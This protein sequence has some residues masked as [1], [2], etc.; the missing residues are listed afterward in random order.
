MP[1]YL[2]ADGLQ[3]SIL[4]ALQS[5]LMSQY[6]NILRL[7]L[8]L[9]ERVYARPKHLCSGTWAHLTHLLCHLTCSY[10]QSAKGHKRAVGKLT[11]VASKQ[12]VE[13]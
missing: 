12:I 8:E 7:A 11:V 10:F 6:S 4:N 1:R 3:K 9:L 13:Y 5:G 2:H